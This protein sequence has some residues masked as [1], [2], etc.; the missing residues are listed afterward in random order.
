MNTTKQL[1]TESPLQERLLDALE[2][3][4]IR[5][6]IQKTTLGDVATEAGVSRTTVYRQFKDKQTLFSA[7][8]LRNMSRQWLTIDKQLGPVSSL[9]EWLLEGVV[10]FHK[11]YTNDEKVQL[12]K[13]IGGISEGLKAALSD[14]GLEIVIKFFLPLYELAKDQNQLAPGLTPED[15]AEWIHRINHTLVDH[16][17]PRIATEADLRRWLAPQ[18]SGGFLRQT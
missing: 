2:R 5:F 7:A 1:P 3:C 10:L 9:S 13:R 16:P 17:S 12:Y 11:I 4:F 15:I 18:I 14:S 6:G 8:V